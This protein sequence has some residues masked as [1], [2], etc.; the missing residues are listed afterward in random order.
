M[1]RHRQDRPHPSAG[2]DAADAGAGILG[3]CR[4]AASCRRA[5]RSR[6]RHGTVASSR[7]AAPRSAPGSTRPTGF[8]EDMAAAI[9][10]HHRPR[11]SSPRRTSSRRSPSNDA[12]VDFSGALNTLA[13]ALTKIANDIRLLGSGPRSGLGELRPARERAGQLDHAG[14]GQSDPVR[15]ADDG[16]GA[17]DRQPS[18]GHRRRA[19]RGISSSTCSSR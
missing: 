5:D 3:L 9:A 14:Q 11:R 19:C 2:R 13:V 8:A 4:A 7:R 18:G 16:R 6:D 12:L 1:G 10:R 15:D 17:G